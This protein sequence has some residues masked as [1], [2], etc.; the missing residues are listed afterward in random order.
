VYPHLSSSCDAIAK[1]AKTLE[2]NRN[3]ALK[4]GYNLHNVNIL[5]FMIYSM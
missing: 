2:L 1:V 4:G 5:H 3:Q